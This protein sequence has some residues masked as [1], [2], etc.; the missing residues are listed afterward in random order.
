MLVLPASISVVHRL[1][2][3]FSLLA[4]AVWLPATVHC[5]LESVSGFE[6]LQCVSDGQN[7]KGNC[8]DDGCCTVEKSQY[9][10]KQARLTIP[11]PDLLPVAFAPVLDVAN[12]LPAEV[13]LGVLT[14]APPEL[15][16]TWHFVSRMALPVRAPSVAS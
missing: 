14:A 8:S 16:Q 2:K 10:S 11:L 3:M 13:S 6:F 1:R 5:E 7:S 15:H 9:K 12:T 4:L